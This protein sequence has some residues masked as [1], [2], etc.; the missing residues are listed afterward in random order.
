LLELFHKNA[1]F[2]PVQFVLHPSSTILN[3]FFLFSFYEYQEQII[4]SLAPQ[5]TPPTI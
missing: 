2:T 5:L 4:V 3:C 1:S